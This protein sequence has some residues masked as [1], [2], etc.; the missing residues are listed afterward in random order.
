MTTGLKTAVVSWTWV[1]IVGSVDVWGYIWHK[2]HG[3]LTTDCQKIDGPCKVE[4]KPL[5][6]KGNQKWRTFNGKIISQVSKVKY[7]NALSM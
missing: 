4:L 2:E 3:Y 7:P 5:G 6:D 1:P